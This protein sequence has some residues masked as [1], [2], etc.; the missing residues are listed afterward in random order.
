M[1]WEK[2]KAL[3]F[4]I[5]ILSLGLLMTGCLGQD[6]SGP[7][8]PMIVTRARH[9][10]GM[11]SPTAT[12]A[13]PIP[14]TTPTVTPSLCQV[15]VT[16]PDRYLDAVIRSILGKPYG[17]ICSSD[18][19]SITVIDCS[20]AYGVSDLT[21]IEHCTNVEQLYL[22]RNSKITD[23]SPLAALSELRVLRLS[24]T[25]FDNADLCDI[26]GLS[27]LRELQLNGTP[28]RDVRALVSFPALRVLGIAGTDV[29]DLSALSA[30]VD[31]QH[32]NINETSIDNLDFLVA[33]TD[34]SG[35]FMKC[36]AVDGDLQA[37]VDNC[38][39]GGLGFGSHLTICPRDYEPKARWANIPYLIS[40]GVKIHSVCCDY[41]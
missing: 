40:H 7:T 11:P 5:L 20:R 15:T 22:T 3:V 18:C 28:L 26:V 12:P 21:G 13:M 2:R 10:I 41:R 25:G 34:L 32:L 14:S 19:Q 37:L 35:L 31:L 33:L 36:C 9:A 16:F 39:N 17:D 24:F 27:G 29:W 8:V 38:D 4:C 23:F 1:A 6:R 30:L